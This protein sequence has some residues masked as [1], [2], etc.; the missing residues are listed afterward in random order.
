[1]MRFSFPFDLL[2]S[3]FF[4]RGKSILFRALASFSF[5]IIIRE[6]SRGMVTF[7]SESLR[8]ILF[9]LISS[10]TSFCS[11]GTT[12]NKKSQLNTGFVLFFTVPVF[13]RSITLVSLCFLHNI[14]CTNGSD[15]P[16]RSLLRSLAC[17]TLIL[18]KRELD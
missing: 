9:S 8:V 4:S 14:I 17:T 6:L 11:L 2:N 12:L 15:E 10:K 1:M 5:E 13:T 3:D 16:K 18:S 7:P